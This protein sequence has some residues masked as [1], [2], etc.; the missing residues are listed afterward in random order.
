MSAIISLPVDFDTMD[1]LIRLAAVLKRP[2]L[3]VAR[4]V[5]ELGL[6]E[7]ERP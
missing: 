3:D 2:V 1:R 5:L 4:E 7:R 6:S